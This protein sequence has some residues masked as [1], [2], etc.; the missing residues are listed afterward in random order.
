MEQMSAD[1]NVENDNAVGDAV[2]EAVEK[3]IPANTSEK[4]SET[5]T[6]YTYVEAA[7]IVTQVF[8]AIQPI[9]NKSVTAAVTMAIS[10]TAKLLF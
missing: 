2:A 10:E 4:N 6:T 3:A 1:N 7:A 9:I 5:D 8:A